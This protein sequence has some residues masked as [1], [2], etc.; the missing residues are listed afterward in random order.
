MAETHGEK[1]NVV[2]YLFKQGDKGLIKRWK[3]RYFILDTKHRRI[4]YHVSHMDLN[5]PL[6]TIELCL[7]QD[8]AHHVGGSDE[9]KY[10]FDVPLVERVYHLM[11]DTDGERNKWI[12]A[13]NQIRRVI[14]VQK[15]K[16]NRK[17]RELTGLEFYEFEKFDEMKAVPREDSLKEVD[18]QESE[19]DK[20]GNGS[21]TGNSSLAVI[22]MSGD[23]AQ[24]SGEELALEEVL[25]PSDEDEPEKSAQRLDVKAVSEKFGGTPAPVSP[26]CHKCG[27]TVYATEKLEV[28]SRLF[29]KQCFRCQECGKVLSLG[30]F[31]GQKGEFYCKPHFQQLFLVKGNYDEGFGQAQH[32]AKWAAASDDSTPQHPPPESTGEPE[33]RTNDSE[34]D[35]HHAKGPE[36][37]RGE[38]DTDLLTK[39][40][41]QGFVTTKSSKT[42]GASNPSEKLPRTVSEKI[43]KQPKPKPT[44]QKSRPVFWNNPEDLENDDKAEGAPLA[45]SENL[46]QAFMDDATKDAADSSFLVEQSNL[47]KAGRVEKEEMTPEA[48][49]QATLTRQMEE[50]ELEKAEEAKRLAKEQEIVDALDRETKKSRS[51]SKKTKTLSSKDD[52]N[53]KDDRKV[54]PSATRSKSVKK[55]AK[56]DVSNEMRELAATYQETILDFQKQIKLLEKEKEATDELLV[57]R[58]QQIEEEREEKERYRRRCEEYAGKEYSHDPTAGQSGASTPP[59]A[60]Q[61]ELRVRELEKELELKELQILKLKNESVKAARNRQDSLIVR[62]EEAMEHRGASRSIKRPKQKSDMGTPLQAKHEELK[63][64]YF[65]FLALSI[66]N[67][68]LE[69]RKFC[70]VKIGHLYEHAQDLD[71]EEWDKWIRLRLE[72]SDARNIES[73]QVTPAQTKRAQSKRTQ[74]HRAQ[75][76][77]TQSQRQ[78]KSSKQNTLH[79]Q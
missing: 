33:G 62:T 29:H 50:E 15:E 57:I 43:T 70:N 72:N 11:A 8:D 20:V 41:D 53:A 12:G 39:L 47:R 76:K 24:P 37:V 4:L 46:E 78:K 79:W 38:G 63:R 34:P 61:H 22:K 75:S 66:K 68:F 18:Q 42:W 21:A 55:S 48:E 65:F 51:S 23:N 69:Q 64:K 5:K 14:Q 28:D 32:K 54:K 6:G 73:P 40:P 60:N 10:Y 30:N 71:F 9:T 49:R 74:P 36:Q 7:L 52:R 17:K 67:E 77:H 31:A 13:I 59:V 45:Q 3:K 27:K 56:T 16:A 35:S 25:V 1:K 44:R 26:K 19:T 58:E 2:G